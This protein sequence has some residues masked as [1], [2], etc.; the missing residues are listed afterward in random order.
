[1]L[2]KIK[3]N[4]IKNIPSV[5]IK[6]SNI[7][8]TISKNICNKLIIKTYSCNRIKSSRFIQKII[9]IL[10][11]MIVAHTETVSILISSISYYIVNKFVRDFFSIW[12][13]NDRFL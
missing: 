10:F 9:D 11:L 1:M 2:F 12:K 7:Y 4:V 13:S 8:K 5:Y 6:I 3:F